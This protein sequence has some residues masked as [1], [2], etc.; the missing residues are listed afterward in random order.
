MP[1]ISSH[2][3]PDEASLSS[4]H[5]MRPSAASPIDLVHLA[6]QTCGDREL[7]RSILAM[8]A[9]QIGSAEARLRALSLTERA[10]LAHA[11]KGTARNVGA[12]ALADAAAQFETGPSNEAA[13]SRLIDHMNM[14][15]RFA[16]ELA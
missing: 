16:A 5:K 8:L 14:T 2:A 11:L 7:E 3:T 13:L 15:R 4:S 1:A 10:T 6:T 9:R 12:F